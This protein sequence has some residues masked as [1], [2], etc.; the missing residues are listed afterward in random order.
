MAVRGPEEVEMTAYLSYD[1]MLDGRHVATLTF[2]Y[3]PLWPLDGNELVEYTESKLP[4]VK[5]KEYEIKF[6]Q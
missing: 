1:V 2:E 3:S 5:G 6:N 4:Q